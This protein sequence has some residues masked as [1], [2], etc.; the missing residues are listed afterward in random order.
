MGLEWEKKF[1]DEWF[2]S[3]SFGGMV[4]DGHS[5]GELDG[6][7]SEKSL[8]CRMLFREAIDFGYRFGGKHAVMLNL[9]H[10]S[11]ANLCKKNTR[12]GSAQGR[13]TVTINEGLE[14]IGIRYKYSF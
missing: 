3:F 7:T 12:D 6:R 9:D 4:H 14:A 2:A 1:W 13:Q 10:S 11:N 8:G 5:V